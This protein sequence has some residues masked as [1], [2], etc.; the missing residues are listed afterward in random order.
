MVSGVLRFWGTDIQKIR[1]RTAD[2]KATLFICEMN[3]LMKKSIIND[4]NVIFNLLNKG[5]SE[6]K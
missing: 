2:I 1:S 5:K 4:L 6:I 3:P